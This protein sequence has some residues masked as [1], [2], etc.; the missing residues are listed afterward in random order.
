ML[1]GV[2]GADWAHA[3]LSGSAVNQ[4]G[5]SASLTAPNGPLQRALF[6]SAWNDA[7]VPFLYVDG[8][9]CHGTVTAL[10]DPIEVGALLSTFG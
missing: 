7:Q 6:E 2:R 10:G 5:R 4:D 1:R 3:L 8:I 9:A